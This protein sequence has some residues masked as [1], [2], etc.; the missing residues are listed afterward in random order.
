LNRPNWIT[1][2]DRKRV[3]TKV[4]EL[5]G[6]QIP[7][8]Y[9]DQIARVVVRISPER[10]RQIEDP[11]E[12]LAI[13]TSSSGHLPRCLLADLKRYAQSE[14]VVDISEAERD[15]VDMAK[16]LAKEPQMDRLK[17]CYLALEAFLEEYEGLM[18]ESTIEGARG[19][20]GE[21]DRLLNPDAHLSGERVLRISVL[22]RHF[23]EFA[24]LLQ[25]AAE[26]VRLCVDKLRLLWDAFPR[27]ID[28]LS[29][30]ALCFAACVFPNRYSHM[31]RRRRIVR[32][33]CFCQSFLRALA[34]DDIA[35][36]V[37]NEVI[38]GPHR[39]PKEQFLDDLAAVPWG[40]PPSP[41]ERRNGVALYV[42][43]LG[44]HDLERMW[45]NWSDDADIVRFIKNELNTCPSNMC[46]NAV[47]RKG[48]TYT[49]N[50]RAII[51]DLR[52][53]AQAY[54]GLNVV[55]I[56]RLEHYLWRSIERAK[57]FRSDS[58]KSQAAESMWEQLWDSLVSGFPYYDYRAHFQWWWR[59]ASMKGEVYLPDSQPAVL[60]NLQDDFQ[61]NDSEG[62]PPPIGDDHPQITISLL[63]FAREGLF[64]VVSTFMALRPH[65]KGPY[66]NV[67]GLVDQ[68]RLRRFLT[69]LWC[70]HFAPRLVDVKHSETI[71]VIADKHSVKVKT[72]HTYSRRMNQRYQ[73][74]TLARAGGWDD[75][76]ILRVLS[77]RDLSSDTDEQKGNKSKER[78]R[79]RVVSNIARLVS[80][81]QPFMI[82]H[83]PYR[84][85]M[86]ILQP[87]YYDS[88]THR[89]AA[90]E[91]RQHITTYGALT[92]LERAL[93][94]LGPRERTVVRVVSDS[95]AAFVEDMKVIRTEPEL[96]RYVREH[97]NTLQ[98][99]A[100]YIRDSLRRELGRGALD[101]FEES[102]RPELRHA[103]SR[104]PYLFVPLWYM[105]VLRDHG[106]GQICEA[107]R[108][109]EDEDRE[110]ARVLCEWIRSALSR[111][112]VHNLES[113]RDS[114]GN[115]R[116]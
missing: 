12:I 13:F 107:L 82:A 43:T 61:D 96:C 65:E 94:T 99:L 4:R 71:D 90:T 53:R 72:A 50:S 16:A 69:H 112:H 48:D 21:L 103:F 37:L 42:S 2:D 98:G 59:Q 58:T 73:A 29:L 79:V 66:K 95:M 74:Y 115:G 97:R 80:P 10:A 17:G 7:A 111:T 30:L 76:S 31:P 32:L 23:L 3:K 88:L 54:P 114:Y 1:A 6:A 81:E 93:P 83:M 101:M 109:E 86:P 84:N 36:Y 102:R 15:F 78:T 9:I 19:L 110:R 5:V 60:D 56:L 27:R 24:S 44:S 28:D 64:F 105:V 113:G 49:L 70:F 68:I 47:T 85:L 63:R 89:T 67:R 75:A 20:L 38:P 14:T 22:G 35:E 52:R 62:A 92:A 33:T 11:E 77:L 39:G 87:R 51:E 26:R 46:I 108:I 34:G 91:A 116:G 18:D 41:E 100:D 106:V 104:E 55:L 40:R 45:E 25:T 8:L 57:G